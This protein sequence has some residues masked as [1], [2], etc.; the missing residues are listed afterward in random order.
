MLIHQ[1]DPITFLRAAARH[2]RPGGVL[3]LHEPILHVG[4]H[5]LPMSPI[6][7]QIDKWFATASVASISMPDA[8][9]GMVELFQAAG[10][11]NPYLFAEVPIGGGRNSNNYTWF[12]ETLNAVKPAL[13]KA[14]VATEAMLSIETLEERLRTELTDLHSQIIGPIHVCVWTT[15]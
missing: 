1:S 13:I 12:V 6:F 15:V 4:L 8:A 11:P 5:S 7:Q 3:A 10:L 14:G 9:G 2:L